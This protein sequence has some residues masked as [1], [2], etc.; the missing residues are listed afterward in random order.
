MVLPKELIRPRIVAT[1]E[2]GGK[3]IA[4]LG[5]GVNV[6]Y[7]Y[8]NKSFSEALIE[9]GAALSFRNS[10]YL[11]NPTHEIFRGEIELFVAWRALR[12]SLKAKRR[13]GR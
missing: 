2:A 3:T 6:I 13:E 11:Q 12:S 4:V 1:Y 7:P 8:S 9:A 5:S 10:R